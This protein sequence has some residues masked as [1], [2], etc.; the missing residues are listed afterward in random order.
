MEL[1]RRARTID[2]STDPAPETL[3]A[4]D[5][6]CFESFDRIYRT[7]CAV[8]FNYVPT[9]GHPGG[10]ISSGR[11][12]AGLLF[13]SMDYDV[14][15]PDRPDADIISYAA[16]HKALGLYALWALRN[17]IARIAAPDLLP[18]DIRHQLRLEDLLGFRRNPITA[19]PLFMKF[20]AKPLDGHP[21]PATPFVRLSTGASGVGVASSLGLALG[22][23]DYYGS[24][25]P[26]VHIIEGDGGLTPGRVSEALAAAGTGSLGNAILHI[27]WNQASI[28]SN[29]VCADEK[30]PGD[31]DRGSAGRDAIRQRPAGRGRLQDDQGLAVRD[32]GPRLPRRG[33]RPLLR[34]I[35][36]GCGS[37]A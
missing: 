22:A 29:R 19:T 4:D 20:K 31:Y 13:D 21:T 12:V 28:D 9:S 6:E 5:L 17:E 37:S 30:G 11:F 16:G 15:D 35:P 25:A 27:D 10:S 7:L 33:T 3:G 36:R 8:M 34:R 14:S 2:V 1:T 26:R 32:R 24:N 18:T 23:I